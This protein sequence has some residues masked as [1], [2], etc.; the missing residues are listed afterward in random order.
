[1]CIPHLRRRELFFPS[2]KVK[3]L[4]YF[5]EFFPEDLKSRELTGSG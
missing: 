5:F 2:F 1:M 3:C 4:Q